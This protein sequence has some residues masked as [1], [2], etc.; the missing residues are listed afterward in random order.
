MI[1]LN[2]SE[3]ACG[4]LHTFISDDKRNKSAVDFIIV[5]ETFVFKVFS[6]KV[7][8]M[9]LLSDHVPSTASLVDCL[10]KYQK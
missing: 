10:R 2:L 9:D 4:Q 6:C 5:P 3:L 1:V 7:G 8:G